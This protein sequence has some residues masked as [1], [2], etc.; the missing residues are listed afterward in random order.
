MPAQKKSTRH[1]ALRAARVEALSAAAKLLRTAERLTT[2]Q[3]SL[4]EI[5]DA[6]VESEAPPNAS[7]NLRGVISYIVRDLLI[8]AVSELSKSVGA[9]DETLAE[10]F[11]AT[12]SQTP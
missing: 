10:Q 3:E 4:P 2:V 12:H 6:V 1:Q 9:T 11:A 5:S 7:E 8:V